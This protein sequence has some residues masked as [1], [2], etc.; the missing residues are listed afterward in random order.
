MANSTQETIQ[1]TRAEYDEIMHKAYEIE[2]RVNVS[3]ADCF[4]HEKLDDTKVKKATNSI[5]ELVSLITKHI[6]NDK[7]TV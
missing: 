2:M 3:Y 1:L 5:G 7:E 6:P 4:K